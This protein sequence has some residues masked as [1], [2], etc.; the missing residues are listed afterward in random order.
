M[1]FA[2]SEL[3]Q[4]VR[5]F[6]EAQGGPRQI[7]G[8]IADHVRLAITWYDPPVKVPPPYPNGFSSALGP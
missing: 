1:A 5:L 7:L 2:L 8:P 3:V 6:P 4:M